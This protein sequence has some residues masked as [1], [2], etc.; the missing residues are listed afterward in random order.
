MTVKPDLLISGSAIGYYGYTLL[1]GQSAAPGFSQQL[2]ADWE[3][4]TKKAEQFE[5]RVCLIRTGLVL[6]EGGELLQRILLPF[7]LGLG[8]RFGNGMQ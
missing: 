8:G 5:V 4:E 6:A 3:N 1:T 2:C 7:L